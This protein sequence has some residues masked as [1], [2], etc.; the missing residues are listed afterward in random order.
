MLQREEFSFSSGEANHEKIWRILIN[1]PHS[2]YTPDKAKEIISYALD[3]LPQYSS[4]D[5]HKM[6]IGFRSFTL[7]FFIAKLLNKIGWTDEEGQHWNNSDNHV[8]QIAEWIFG[9]NQHRQDGI[10]ENLAAK[11]RGL[12]GLR[13]LLIFRL[14]CCADR[15]GD[16]FNLSR[17]LSIH[18][19]P[20]NPTEGT[21]NDI[22]IGEMREISQYIFRIFK[23]DI[24][25]RKS[26]FS[27]K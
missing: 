11:E 6:N 1:S 8:I 23:R 10:L 14:C 20:D 24:L 12:L 26:I 22:V 7:I 16:M 19:G 21:V 15:G 4:L 17:A 3:S 5:I 2:E 18:G 13:D 9:E 25:T 27:M